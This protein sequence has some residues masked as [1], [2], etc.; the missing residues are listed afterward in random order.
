MNPKTVGV[1]S[2]GALCHF[3][4][5]TPIRKIHENQEGL[6]MNGTDHLVV[7]VDDVN[8]LG[9]DINTIKNTE[10]LFEASRKAG[11]EVNTGKSKWLCL[12]TRM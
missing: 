6:E 12:S 2:T 9:E 5:V 1:S 10:D 3:I 11:L 4:N 8:V 7:C